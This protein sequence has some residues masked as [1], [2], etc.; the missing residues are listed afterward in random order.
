LRDSEEVNG[1]LAD[2]EL[3]KGDRVGLEELLNELMGV[4]KL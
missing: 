1:I 3:F 4:V 2:E